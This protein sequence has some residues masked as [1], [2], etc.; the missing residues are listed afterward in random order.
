[1][2]QV[3]RK[4]RLYCTT[5]VSHCSLKVRWVELV[6]EVA[7]FFAERALAMYDWSRTLCA[8][9]IRLGGTCCLAWCI[10]KGDRWKDSR[11]CDIALDAFMSAVIPDVIYTILQD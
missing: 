1:M 10:G 9:S 6:A 8:M 3:P 2:T 5:P 7:V 11:L 4:I